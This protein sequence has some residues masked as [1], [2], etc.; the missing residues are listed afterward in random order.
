MP[1]RAALAEYGILCTQF[2][3]PG[4]DGC[5]RGAR[6]GGEQRIDLRARLRC[7]FVLREV[8]D[9]AVANASP[10]ESRGRDGEQQRCGDEA[11][12]QRAILSGHARLPA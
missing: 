5:E 1:G 6:L 11:T 10:A 2:V 4:R 7:E 12:V 3:G 8:G 9:E